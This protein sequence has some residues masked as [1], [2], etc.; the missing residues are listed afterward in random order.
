[1]FRGH[2]SGGHGEASANSDMRRYAPRL[3]CTA[4]RTGE[5]LAY[6]PGSCP[7]RSGRGT[8]RAVHW[9]GSARPA[10]ERRIAFFETAPT[11]SACPT[12]RSASF[13]PCAAGSPSALEHLSTPGCWSTGRRCRRSLPRS[14]CC[15]VQQ[16]GLRIS[17]RPAGVELTSELFGMR[18]YCS[19]DITRCRSPARRAV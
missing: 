12:T 11:A 13:L 3:R 19:S 15:A 1:M 2:R 14:P 9:L 8:G 6:S 5:R 18:P 10:R 16:M 7:R 4:N 17:A